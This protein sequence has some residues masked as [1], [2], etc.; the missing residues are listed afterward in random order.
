[1]KIDAYAPADQRIQLALDS[2]E[3][4]ERACCR[5]LLEELLGDPDLASA[6]GSMH[7]HQAW[8]G[9]YLDHVAEVVDLAFV[10]YEALSK[11]RPLPFTLS[12]A[13]L[14]LFLHDIEKP[15]KYGKGHR[16]LHKLDRHL[17]RMKLIKDSGI[18]LTS[19]QENAIKYVEGEGDD[20]TPG[21][22]VMG[23]LAAFCH[24]CD[25]LS[26]RMWWDEPK[27]PESP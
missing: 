23:P 6:Q 19:E 20:Y 7:N 11:I 5:R 24:T 4:P 25:V 21:E 8:P 13:L 10:Q 14:V 22:R 9:G 1:M 26:A 27:A 3:P 17:F 12:E 18:E 15:W 2:V 16:F